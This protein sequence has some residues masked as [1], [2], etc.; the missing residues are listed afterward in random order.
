MAQNFFMSSAN[1]HRTLLR[2]HPGVNPKGPGQWVADENGIITG[3]DVDTDQG[4]KHIP[5]EQ[6]AESW[7]KW[8]SRFEPHAFEVVNTKDG[9]LVRNRE[10]GET[11]KTTLKDCTCESYKS[12]VENLELIQLVMKSYLPKCKHMRFLWEVSHYDRTTVLY[13]V[14]GDELLTWIWPGQEPIKSL[15]T[16][17]E[18]EVGRIGLYWRG[19]ASM[20]PTVQA[21]CLSR[22]WTL[23]EWHPY[24]IPVVR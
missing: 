21:R 1:L 10:N 18:I 5:M 9:R 3:V 13:R 6:L 11:Y 23:D 17:K 24:G 19:K 2:V 7:A 16:D 15:I 4:P 12:Q 8:V 14:E 20:L 22:G